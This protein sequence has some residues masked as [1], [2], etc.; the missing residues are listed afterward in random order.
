VWIARLGGTQWDLAPNGQ[1][2]ESAEGPKEEHE[3]PFLENFCDELWR[4][5]PA[6]KTSLTDHGGNLG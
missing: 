2:V 6:N 1:R 4:K 3:V 5:V